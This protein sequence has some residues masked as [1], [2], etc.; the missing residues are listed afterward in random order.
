MPDAAATVAET[1]RDYIYHDNLPYRL[2]PEMGHRAKIGL[3][4]LAP[5]WTIE[6]EVTT[7][8]D[9]PGVA[10]FSNRIPMAPEVNLETLRAMGP[11]IAAC[12]D[13]LMPGFELD[14]VAYGCTSGTI[15]IGKEALFES[16]RSVRPGVACTTPIVAGVAGWERLGI[17]RIALMTPYIEEV[18]VAMRGFVLDHG[19]DVPV[20]GTFNNPVDVEVAAIDGQSLYDGIMKLG[21]S[22]EVDGVFVSCTSLHVTPVIARAEEALGKPVISS[23]LALSWHSLRL[24]GVEDA[25]PGYGRLMTL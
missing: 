20:V 17:G 2:G 18:N 11:N 23:N 5:D 7:L 6:H 1:R 12:A 9:L 22:D 16:I 8:C 3:I 21:A 13:L 19:I 24:A 14:V 4:V 25:V 15:A 10:V